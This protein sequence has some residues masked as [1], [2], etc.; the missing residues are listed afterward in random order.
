MIASGMA[1]VR[2]KLWYILIYIDRDI[3]T[4]VNIYEELPSVYYKAVYTNVR[5]KIHKC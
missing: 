5:P 3:I 2:A 4:C 1:S